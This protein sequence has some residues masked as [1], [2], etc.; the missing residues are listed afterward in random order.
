MDNSGHIPLS[1]RDTT[2]ADSTR[3]WQPEREPVSP[4][5][6][7]FK[8]APCVTD[9]NTP[10]GPRLDLREDQGGA[11]GIGDSSL[12]DGL[13]T[14]H[15]GAPRDL[16]ANS[17]FAV[18]PLTRYP[19]E[20]TKSGPQEFAM[21]WIGSP[22]YDMEHIAPLTDKIFRAIARFFGDSSEPFRVF[23]RRVWNGHGGTG[24]HR[25]FL[26][27]YSSNTFEEQNEDA[28]IDLLA[29]KTVHSEYPLL[30]PE[31]INNMWYDEGVANYYATIESYEQGAVG[32]NDLIK[33]LNNQAQAH[34]TA[35]VIIHEWKY[36]LNHYWDGYDMTKGG[37]GRG[38]IYLCQVQGLI[39]QATKG[40][41][42]VD[43]I[44]LAL[45][46]RQLQPEEFDGGDFRELLS[47]II[48]EEDTNAIREV[49]EGG[50]VIVPVADCFAK[51][52]LKLVRHDVEKFKPGFD[53][54]SLRKKKITDLVKGSRAE[55]AG[56]HEGDEVV[57]SWMLWVADDALENM[58]QVTVLRDGQEQLIKY[59]PRS[60]EKV[61]N[62]FWVE[63]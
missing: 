11:F 53:P 27:E 49:M 54:N 12:G 44:V 9:A 20:G 18:G 60:H 1:Y 5:V 2:E 29:H 30:W 3:T 17:F 15:I 25:S 6:I 42:G 57:H 23:I 7:Q 22:P 43:D 24:G 52:G 40:K 34:Y 48:G 45:Y 14:S 55:K 51:Y 59:W 63:I 32:R 21:Y 47:D 36:I 28:L 16:V 4:I 50:K 31:N 8:A 62:W 19:P 38:F 26:L 61:Q 13:Y 35:N 39:R 56:L 10:T 37:Y 41:K 33:A 58:M 46:Q